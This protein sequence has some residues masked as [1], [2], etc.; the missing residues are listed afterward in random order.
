MKTRY[1]KLLEKLG[2]NRGE[3]EVY[4]FLL[5]T[6]TL[7]ANE[8]AAK[9]GLTR[10]NTYNIIEALKEKGLL[11][12]ERGQ[13]KKLFR[14]RHPDCLKLLI[15][16][17]RHD[18]SSAQ[19]ELERSYQELVSDFALSQHS[20][21]VF[22]FA[23]KEGMERAYNELLKD[24]K[25]LHSIM[26]RPKY[27][28]FMAQF[29]PGFVRTRVKKR[30]FHKIISPKHPRI[31]EDDGQ[32]LRQVRYLSANTFPWSMDIKINSERVVMTTLTE[33]AAAGIIIHDPVIAGN[34]LILFNFLWL[35]GTPDE[36]DR[37]ENRKT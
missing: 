28:E 2:L 21:G 36:E 16:Q 17:K 20:I 6:G 11:E 18:L 13:S 23:G 1:T 34:F 14:A 31:R 26:N 15:D 8:I 27:R 33:D 19:E 30:I 22:R 5:R 37:S 10:T 12:D 24:G 4:D 3:M 32:L 29:N 25:D 9:V 35:T 7:P